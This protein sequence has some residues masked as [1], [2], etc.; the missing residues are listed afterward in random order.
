LYL[1]KLIDTMAKT[2]FTFIFVFILVCESKAQ[3]KVNDKTSF[4]SQSFGIQGGLTLLENPFVLYPVVN[5]SYSKTILGHKRHQLAI[6]PQF[7]AIFLPD[8]ETKVLISTSL[9]YKYISKKRFEANIFLGVNYQ[10]RRLAYNRY[11]Y[12]ENIL[13]KKGKSL[14]QFGPTLGVNLGYKVI[15]KQHFSLSPFLG[16]SLTKLNKSYQPNLFVGYK[17][18]L[19]FGLTF[20]N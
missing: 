16:I 8:I 14:H 7:G 10:L 11:Q 19:T 6:L 5:L 20:N 15:K 2:I 17:P 3:D 12:E 1:I 18:G 13:K 4:H 9:Q